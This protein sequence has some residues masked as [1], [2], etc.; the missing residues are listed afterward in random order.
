MFAC[1]FNTVA[2]Y[3]E[4]AGSSKDIKKL[5]SNNFLGHLGDALGDANLSKMFHN[6][7]NIFM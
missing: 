5:N 6:C 3:A 2:Q 1:V 7:C 4:Y